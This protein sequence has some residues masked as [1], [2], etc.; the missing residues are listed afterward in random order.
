MSSVLYDITERGQ[1]QCGVD[2]REH[3]PYALTPHK[4]FRA[5][6]A[7]LH[8]RPFPVL[9]APLSVS[10][11]VLKQPVGGCANAA[12]A[13]LTAL[14]DRYSVCAPKPGE[15]CFY[16]DFGEFEVRWEKHFEF[17]SYSFIVHGESAVPFQSPPIVLLPADW[18]SALS[19]E[20]VAAVHIEFRNAAPEA[21]S[22]QVLRPWFEG[23]RL[24]GSEIASGGATMWS[25]F[26]LHSD[27]FNRIL[28]ENRTLNDCQT[29]R[30]LRAL[31]ELET[32][33]NMMLL[34]FPLAREIST[35]I[36]RMERQ[37]SDAVHQMREING[38]EDEHRRLNELS[39]MAGAV[40]EMIADTRYR[41]D[42]TNA[43][44]GL[45][46]SRLT[47]LEEREICDLQT[48]KAFID[49]RLSPAFRTVQ[50]A[51]RRMDD[52]A[53]RID[54]A[55]EFLR[56]RVEMSIEAQN[57]RLLVSM[58]QRA[59]LQLTLQQTVEGLSVLV[60]SYYLVALAEK[61]LYGVAFL[62][63]GIE[64][65]ALVAACVPVALTA[66]WFSSRRWKR[67]LKTKG[68]VPD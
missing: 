19:G 27:A 45:V 12:L 15:T 65:S 62:P 47:E 68:G 14:C 21:L 6:Y 34:A 16:Q 58:D 41:F 43:Y 18:L 22:P 31:L 24:I 32:Y 52:L 38:V 2:L 48:V 54:S 9:S 37:L 29:G 17:C 44:Y 30:V 53:R 64:K 46:L 59:K 5:G 67:H 8:N 49:R 61:V 25:A 20:L 3:Y 36:T 66:V 56:T 63:A 1:E 7:E 57:N 50:A 4:N 10:H 28:V 26:R 33:R 42:A 13:H 35:R 40:A 60:L 11:V 39:V 23:Q 55:S 51:Q